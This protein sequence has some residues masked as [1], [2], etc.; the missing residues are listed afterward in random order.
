MATGAYFEWT[1]LLGGRMQHLKA[2][3]SFTHNHIPVELLYRKFK[4][5]VFEVWH[6]RILFSAN[7]EEDRTFTQSDHIHFFHGSKRAA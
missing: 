7:E 4:N 3:N 5:Q 6:C 2:G 1:I